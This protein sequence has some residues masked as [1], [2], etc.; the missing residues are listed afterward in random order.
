MTQKK[1]SPLEQEA[2]IIVWNLKS[3]HVREVMNKFKKPL[4][5]TTVATLLLR[6]YKKDMVSRKNEGSTWL[7][8]PK[9]SSES[10]GKKMAKSF[11]VNFFESFG[12]SAIVSF[13]ESVES[14]PRKKREELLKLLTNHNENK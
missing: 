4:A 11:M 10:Y 13:A 1:L 7:Y 9:S 8:S 12:E 3:C 2:M 6:L 14:L 5:Y